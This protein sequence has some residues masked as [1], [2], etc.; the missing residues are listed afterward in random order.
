MENKEDGGGRKSRTGHCRNAVKVWNHPMGQDPGKEQA[1]VQ[2]A[3][4]LG[5]RELD[6]GEPRW[7]HPCAGAQHR[8]HGATAAG[9]HSMCHGICCCPAPWRPCCLPNQTPQG[10][11]G[12]PSLCLPLGLVLY[13]AGAGSNPCQWVHG[14]YTCSSGGTVLPHRLLANGFS[15]CA[16]ATALPIASCEGSSP[17]S[18]DTDV[19]E[20][21]GP[22]AMGW[23]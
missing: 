1:L 19:T 6:W 9:A 8:G 15:L 13:E 12:L 20:A 14:P 22:R 4:S 7:F 16:E 3:L 10:E 17:G 11:P 5:C 18:C 23:S 2:R 21:P